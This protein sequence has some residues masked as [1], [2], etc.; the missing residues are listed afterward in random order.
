MKW[1][2]GQ[3]RLRPCLYEPPPSPTEPIPSE[4][5]NRPAFD[6]SGEGAWEKEDKFFLP[7]KASPLS[8]RLLWK[9]IT[10]VINQRWM[11]PGRKI[12][13]RSLPGNKGCLWYFCLGHFAYPRFNLY[14]KA[15]PSSAQFILPESQSR[16]TNLHPASSETLWHSSYGRIPSLTLV[17]VRRCTTL[18]T[19]ERTKLQ[20]FFSSCIKN[21]FLKM[22]P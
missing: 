21:S 17:L 13:D 15:F 3:A 18:F 20:F 7:E 19:G 11:R 6:L 16:R 1:T 12:S 4:E 14:R 8:E 9:L 2:T 10:G 5:P 22:L